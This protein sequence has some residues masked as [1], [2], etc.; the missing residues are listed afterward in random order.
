MNIFFFFLTASLLKIFSFLTLFPLRKFDGQIA[1]AL[2][3]L[4][5]FWNHV[6]LKY[7]EIKYPKVKLQITSILV[8]KVQA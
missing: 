5:I 6:S 7:R 8:I 3:Y 1:E 2:Q 4:T